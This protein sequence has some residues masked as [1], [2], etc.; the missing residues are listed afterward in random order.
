M[1]TSFEIFHNEPLVS[2]PNFP[3]EPSL[4]SPKLL[5][6]RWQITL[7][8]SRCWFDQVN[9]FNLLDCKRNLVNAIWQTQF[10]GKNHFGGPRTVPSELFDWHKQRIHK[11]HQWCRITRGISIRGI[12]IFSILTHLKSFKPPHCLVTHH[13]D[14]PHWQ[15]KCDASIKV[16]LSRL[17]IVCAGNCDC[18][19]ISFRKTMFAFF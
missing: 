10:V 4:A 17:E 7:I 3:D 19:A 1:R 6:F 16:T 9:R 15:I 13:S 5:T 14:S 11:R 18:G 8:G 12:S 2:F